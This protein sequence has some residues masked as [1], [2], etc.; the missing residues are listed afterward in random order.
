MIDAFLK[1]EYE[2]KLFQKEADG[3]KYWHMIRIEIYNEI[4]RIKNDV[5]KPHFSNVY[6]SKKSIVQS[7]AKQLTNI[8]YRNPFLFLEQ[9]DVLIFNHSRRV[10]QENLYKCLYTDPLIQNLDSNYYVYEVPYNEFHFRPVPEDK[11]KYTDLIINRYLAERVKNKLVNKSLLPKQQQEEIT[12]IILQLNSLFGVSLDSSFWINKISNKILYFNMAYDAY[13]KIIKKIQPKVIVQVVSY[14]NSRFV[15]NKLAKEKGIPTIELQH[16]TMGKYHIAYNFLRNV[17]LDTFPDYLFTFGDF[18]K[19]NTRL[20]IP[21]ENVI[22]IG[23][24]F[25]ENKLKEYKKN[26]KTDRKRTILFVSQGSIGKELSRFA[27]ELEK[28]LDSKQYRIVYK[29]HPGEYEGWVTNY[30]WLKESKMEIIDNSSHDMHYYFAQ[31]DIQIGVYSTALFEGLGYGLKTL[32]V[33]L[34]GA[35]HMESL[36]KAEY[37]DLVDSVEEAQQ[38]IQSGSFTEKEFNREYFWKPNS[39]ENMMKKIREIIKVSEQGNVGGIK[40]HESI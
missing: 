22:S 17:D 25:Y 37:A 21:D 34:Y 8:F 11:I 14:L 18:W 12:E 30:P 23:W 28:K 39:T 31:S 16:G 33:N 27:L 15:I 20:P 9:K 24:P 35:E 7:K 13:D 32:I 10:K 2:K 26:S 19:E 29:L 6:T 4:N 1:F 40:K 38:I 3:V 36:Y 5:E